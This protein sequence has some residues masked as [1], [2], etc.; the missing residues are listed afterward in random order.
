[1]AA[2]SSALSASELKNCADMMVEKPFFIRNAS[3]SR[4]TDGQG[5]RLSPGGAAVYSMRPVARRPAGSPLDA[6]AKCAATVPLRGK[7]GCG[8]A[9][10]RSA[11]PPRRAGAQLGARASGGAGLAGLGGGQGQRLRARHRARLRRA[12]RRRRF[13]AARPGRSRAAARAGLARPDPAAGRLLR[14]ARPGAVL[15]PEPVACGA[16]R[17]ADRMAGRTQDAGA[18]SRVP[19]DEQRHEPP[20]LHAASLPHLPGRG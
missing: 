11:D 3:L 4:S 16:L 12:A 2:T 20:G 7:G 9:S 18:A 19:E 14:A 1:M 8:A 13:C 15:A 5:A 10:D 6:L 17:G